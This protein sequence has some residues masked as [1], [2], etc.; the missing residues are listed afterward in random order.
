MSTDEHPVRAADYGD[1]LRRDETPA[2]R[3]DRNMSELLQELRVAQTGVQILFAFLLTLAFQQR[4]TEV[5]SFGRAMYI[6]ALICALLSSGFLI[7]PVGYHRLVFRRAMKDEVVKTANIFALIGL[8]WLSLALGG[9]LTVILDVMFSK[10]VA[11]TGG[12][13]ALVFLVVLWFL[14][15]WVRLRTKRGDFGADE[16]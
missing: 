2:E 16:E 13:I 11:A 14:I 12:L 15:P 10:D 4:F 8:V 3:L 5:D 1:H 9:A 6:G 7:A